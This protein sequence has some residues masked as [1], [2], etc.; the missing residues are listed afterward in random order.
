ML[1]FSA[2][3][4]IFKSTIDKPIPALIIFLMASLLLNVLQYTGKIGV[5]HTDDPII[6]K[7]SDGLSSTEQLVAFQKETIMPIINQMQQKR[8]ENDTPVLQAEYAE[9]MEKM[10][11]CL[12]EEQRLSNEYGWSGRSINESESKELNKALLGIWNR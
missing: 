3:P 11:A 1:E 10:L 4:A 6:K 5:M 8:R 7:K 9:M 2:I 12:K